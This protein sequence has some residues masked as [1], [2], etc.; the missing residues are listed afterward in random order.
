MHYVLYSIE[1]TYSDQKKSLSKL[2][3]YKKHPPRGS[4]PR[5]SS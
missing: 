1:G 3:V 4:N 5:P 2:K